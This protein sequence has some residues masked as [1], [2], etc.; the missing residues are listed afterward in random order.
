MIKLNAPEQSI[1]RIDEKIIPM[2]NIIFLLLM[3]FLIMG[4]IS[5]LVREDVIPPRSSSAGVLVSAPAQWILARD[6]TIIMQEQEMRLNQVVA[7]LAAP[8]NSLPKRVVLRVDGGAMSGALLPLMD[9]MRDHGV[10]KISLVTINDA[11]NR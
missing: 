6:G 7:W 8:G 2:I 3:F 9:L 4:N 11:G 5:E 10:D 1:K